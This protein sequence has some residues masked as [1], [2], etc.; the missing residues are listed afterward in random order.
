MKFKSHELVA[1]S[2]CLFFNRT[3]FQASSTGQSGKCVQ[4]GGAELTDNVVMAP[5][6]GGGDR[7]FGY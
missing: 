3:E 4:G 6:V 1:Q 7:G 5:N 2:C